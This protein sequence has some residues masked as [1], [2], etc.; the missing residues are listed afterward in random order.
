MTD[1]NASVASITRAGVHGFH[2]PSG[3]GGT[4]DFDTRDTRSANSSSAVKSGVSRLGRIDARLARG[5]SDALLPGRG[6]G[7]VLLTSAGG[8]DGRS[9]SGIPSI[10]RLDDEDGNRSL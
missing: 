2:R 10:R 1:A 4:S 5:E 9:V 3:A 7:A 8:A 6:G